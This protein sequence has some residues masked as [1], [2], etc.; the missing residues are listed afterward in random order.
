M[1]LVTW[2]ILSSNVCLCMKCFDM[3]NEYVNLNNRFT[4][5]LIINFFESHDLNIW[6]WNGKTTIIIK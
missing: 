6:K 4:N 1:C 2:A 5:P 3:N